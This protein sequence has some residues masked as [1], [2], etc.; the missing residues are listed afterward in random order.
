MIL[1]NPVPLSEGLQGYGVVA[2][3]V[4]TEIRF[5]ADPSSGP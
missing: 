3:T 4:M 5:F 2:M 1:G